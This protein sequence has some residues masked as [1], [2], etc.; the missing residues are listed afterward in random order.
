MMIPQSV[1]VALDKENKLLALQLHREARLGIFEHTMGD[2]NDALAAILGVC[3]TQ[4]KEITPTIKGHILTI[5]LR[6]REARNY[7]AEYSQKGVFNINLACLNMCAA[8]ESYFRSNSV[9]IERDLAS[10]NALATG[11]LENFEQFLLYLFLHLINGNKGVP[12]DIKLITRQKDNQIMIIIR[13]PRHDFFVEELQIL[14]TKGE[15]SFPGRIRFEPFDM[16]I[17][18][19]LRLPLKFPTDKITLSEPKLKTKVS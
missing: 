15:E 5:N 4:A 8:I 14:K 1:H 16:G 17:E 3:D 13:K 19:I 7:Y 18:I 9:R 11:N 6:L 10:I 2:V 12:A